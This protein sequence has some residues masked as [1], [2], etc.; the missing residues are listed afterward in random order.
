[1]CLWWQ[2]PELRKKLQQ[3][4]EMFNRIL[5]FK[6]RQTALKSKLNSEEEESKHKH[7]HSD[8]IPENICCKTMDCISRDVKEFEERVDVRY[9]QKV[10]RAI[11]RTRYKK[12]I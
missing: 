6:Q 2:R 4:I 5:T 8:G 9:F 3:V 11:E 7:H 1:M 10:E 12:K